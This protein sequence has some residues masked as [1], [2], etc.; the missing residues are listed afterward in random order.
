M[1]ETNRGEIGKMVIVQD[2]YG[3]SECRRITRIMYVTG[4]SVH[5]TDVKPSAS[6]EIVALC[7]EEQFHWF[8]P[9]SKAPTAQ[10]V[11]HLSIPPTGK[12]ALSLMGSEE[13]MHHFSLA[14]AVIAISDCPLCLRFIS[15]SYNESPQNSATSGIPS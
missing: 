14:M 15:C 3:S 10:N 5:P 13:E 7:P 4:V 6:T 11:Y 8:H 12:K 2:T 1:N 9:L